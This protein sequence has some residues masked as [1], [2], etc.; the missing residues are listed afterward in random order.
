MS[1]IL[2]SLAFLLP[3][4]SLNYLAS[5]AW[6]LIFSRHS[7]CARLCAAGL[8]I[9]FNS[10]DLYNPTNPTNT[11]L[12]L[13]A[14][15]SVRTQTPPSYLS[16]LHAIESPTIDFAASLRYPPT[17]ATGSSTGPAGAAATGSEDEAEADNIS[18]LRTPIDPQDEWRAQNA[19]S[20][21]PAPTGRHSAR[22]AGAADRAEG[23]ATAD[24]AAAEDELVEQVRAARQRLS[25]AQQQQ[26]N[27]RRGDGLTARTTS[28]E[29]P[30]ERLQRILNTLSTRR[31]FVAYGDRIN[32]SNSLYGWAPPEGYLQQQGRWNG[33]SGGNSERR[34]DARGAGAAGSGAGVGLDGDD[35]A[36]LHQLLTTLRDQQPTTHPEILRV[37]ARSQLDAMRE[38][39]RGSNGNGSGNRAS[40]GGFTPSTSQ[41]QQEQPTA[42]TDDPT[43]TTATSTPSLRSAT[44]LGSVRRSGPHLS[45]GLTPVATATTA[46]DSTQRYTT[47][48]ERE[49]LSYVDD[50]DETRDRER[51][52]NREREWER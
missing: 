42:T 29:S 23:S 6:K 26:P 21:S 18:F 20:R 22:H 15:A 10:Q 1:A 38:A 34:G 13:P 2:L 17:T 4:S 47:E 52:R 7:A 14:S 40:T 24:F 19:S 31:E 25:R 11:N 16:A 33:S 39:Q 37:L 30:R 9:A 41:Q 32:G 46:R 28:N 48:R 36:E 49:L 51:E 12:P 50:W 3:G 43:P 35:E 27:G 44:I 8:G 45:T 5:V